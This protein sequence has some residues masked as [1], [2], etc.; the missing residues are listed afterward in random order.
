M[1]IGMLD[2]RQERGMRLAADHAALIKK[3]AKNE[4]IVP[5]QANPAES[6]RVKAPKGKRAHWKCSCPDF[7]QR[8]QA[9][10]HIWA[11]RFVGAIH[12]PA[13]ESQRVSV[14]E[15]PEVIHGVVCK[16]C[17][18]G[19]VTRYGMCGKKPAYWCNPCSRKF[20]VDDGFKRVRSDPKSVTLALDLY[21]KGV[22]LRQITDTLNQFF[23]V[24]VNH[25]TVYRWLTRYVTLLNEYAA[26]LKPDVG[27]AKW[28]ADEMKVKYG[29]D[30]RWLWHVMD[31]ETRYLLVSKVTDSRDL[32]DARGVFQAAKDQAGGETPLVI[33]TDGLPAYVDAAKKV[34]IA[35]VKHDARHEREI[36]LTDHALNNNMVERLNSTVRGRQRPARGLKRSSGP[37]TAGQATYYNHIRPH[38]ALGGQTPA[39][40]AGIGVK[41][42]LGDSRWASI[43]KKAVGKGQ[44]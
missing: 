1:A 19:N 6:Y 5:S 24:R 7:A 31:R 22:S 30:W 43:I 36:H 10:K 18:S 34:F 3:F 38:S 35:G 32:A 17:A 26:N 28:H 33:V 42:G 41:G 39:E 15:E 8:G 12:E 13:P 9:C 44:K 14:T 29:A 37:L 23:D 4:W 2:A 27:T 20:V 16:H 21:F 11:V 25:T 40:A